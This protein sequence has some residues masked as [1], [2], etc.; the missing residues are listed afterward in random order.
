MDFIRRIF[1]AKPTPQAST[2]APDETHED[3]S[4]RRAQAL[5][6]NLN[7]NVMAR[8]ASNAAF[9]QAKADGKSREEAL[10]LG[11]VAYEAAR[12]AWKPG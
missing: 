11:D 8:D 1:G 2:T 4:Q 12:L 6:D 7:R 9:T 5:C 10:A 3:R